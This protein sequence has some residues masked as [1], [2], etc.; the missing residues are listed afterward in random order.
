MYGY[1]REMMKTSYLSLT[2]SISMLILCANAARAEAN[3][4]GQKVA[5]VCTACHG[6]G[7]VSANDLWPNL[8]GQKKEYLVKQ[9]LAFQSGERKDSMMSPIASTLSKEDVQSVAAY[10]SSLK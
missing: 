3:L 8:A 9:L 2:I 4:A 1:E 6:A 7:G 5:L 10:F